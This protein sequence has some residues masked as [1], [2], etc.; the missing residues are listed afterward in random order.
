IQLRNAAM[1]DIQQHQM[2][3]G[4]G[5]DSWG[6]VR[7]GALGE[8]REKRDSRDQ[9]S[10]RLDVNHPEGHNQMETGVEGMHPTHH[11]NLQADAF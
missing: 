1:V 6:I 7:K 8:V 10:G 2:T 3:L 9:I 11:A 4:V 5:T